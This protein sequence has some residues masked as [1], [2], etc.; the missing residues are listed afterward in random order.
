MM[1]GVTLNQR[2][3]CRFG[4]GPSS[5]LWLKAR[6]ELQPALAPEGPLDPAALP[7]DAGGMTGK[8]PLERRRP[9]ARG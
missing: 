1:V 6:S 2:R 3:R 7:G 8:T 4:G 9:T 5:P